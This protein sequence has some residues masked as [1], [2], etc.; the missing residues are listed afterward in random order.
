MDPLLS[1]GVALVTGCGS[2]IGQA[3]ALQF[4]HQ[5]CRKIFLADLSITGLQATEATIREVAADARVKL[6]VVDVSDE[7]AVK[8]MVDECVSVFG[9]VDFAC[10]NAGMITGSVLTHEMDVKSFERVNM[11][12]GKGT[13]LCQK[14]EVAAM[15][16]QE[17]LLIPDRKQLPRGSI[18]NTASVAG[19]AGVP[20]V[21]AYAA[22]KHGVISMTRVDA[23][24][25]AD[26]GVRINCVCP[27][28][29]DTPM[30]TGGMP[31]E[32]VRGA[33]SQAPMKRLV[34]PF[35][36]ASAVTFLSGSNA[37]AVTGISL[38]VDCGALL[39][40]IV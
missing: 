37:T 18:V 21:A 17:P 15:L 23:R 20:G 19:L 32:F 33:A 14:Y 30:L 39:Y 16:L 8:D 36:V 11:V 38:P 7:H 34:E 13:F 26:Q 1:Q 35:E 27:G 40:H 31:D 29:T 4:V 2:G 25:Y 6:Y 10:N 22:S 3:I 28:Y 9:R 5:G 24:Q 12:N